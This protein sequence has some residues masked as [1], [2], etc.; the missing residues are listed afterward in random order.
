MEPSYLSRGLNLSRSSNSLNSASELLV[1]KDKFLLPEKICAQC[2]ERKVK[3]KEIF[4]KLL[5]G[6]AHKWTFIYKVE[7]PIY[8]EPLKLCL[9]YL[10]LTK[11]E[12]DGHLA[13]LNKTNEIVF[14]HSHI[15]IILKTDFQY[16]FRYI[17]EFNILL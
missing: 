6:S 13:T 4:V 12:I 5:T 15:F 10:G 11:Y 7:C 16:W 14:R 17:R 2:H 9:K 3:I 8:K 1:R